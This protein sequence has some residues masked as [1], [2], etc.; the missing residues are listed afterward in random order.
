MRAVLDTGVFVRALINPHS[1]NGRLIFEHASRFE[2][3]VSKQTVQELL[4]VIRRPELTSKYRGLA[5]LNLQRVIDAIAQAE[6]VTI[7]AVPS[8]SRDP[9][10]DIFVATALAGRADYLVSLDEDLLVLGSVEGVKIVSPHTFISL[11]EV[12]EE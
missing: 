10:D 4:E 3:L 6:A 12:H 2:L 1:R 9:K 5:K 8:Y 7:E 11:F